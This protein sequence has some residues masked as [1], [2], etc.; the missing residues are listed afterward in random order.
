MKQNHFGI[1]FAGVAGLVAILACG[2]GDSEERQP[3]AFGAEGNRLLAYETQ[4]PWAVQT[5][6]ERYSEDPGGWDINGQICFKPDGSGRFYCRGGYGTADTACRVWILSARRKTGWGALGDSRRKADTDLSGIAE[7][8]RTL[9]LRFSER[10]SA[11]DHG[12]GESVLG[13]P[14]RPVDHLVSAF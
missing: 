10:R 8:T 13:P 5:V 12:C 14:D 3:I 9:W 7:P 4:E 1:R 2:C 6:I 11:S